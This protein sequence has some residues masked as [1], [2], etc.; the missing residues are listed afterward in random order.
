MYYGYQ[1]PGGVLVK[2]G[3]RDI[4][5][6]IPKGAV[7]LTAEQYATLKANPGSLSVVDGVVASTP[8]PNPIPALRTYANNKRDRLILAGFAYDGAMFDSDALSVEK[9]TGAAL[10]ASAALMASAPFS[11][12][13]TDAVG[14]NH[15]LD[16]MGMLALHR[17]L[18]VYADSVHGVCRDVKAAIEAG[19]IT[20]I[21]GIDAA[22][23]PQ[24]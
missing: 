18:V 5:K 21:A 16:A 15:T 12:T 2:P 8:A 19:T 24:P 13:W 11:I 14:A 3:G 20:D 17:A 6:A 1:M 10:Q 4:L 23:W 7:E 9:L 22:G